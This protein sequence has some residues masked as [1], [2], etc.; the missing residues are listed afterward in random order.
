MPLTLSNVAL[1]I[2]ILL[3]LRRRFVRHLTICVFF[4]FA[5]HRALLTH[6]IF[7]QILPYLPELYYT[8]DQCSRADA[9]EAALADFARLAI[10]CKA[11]QE[12]ALDLLWKDIDSCA[13]F[14]LVLDPSLAT[15]EVEDTFE[16]KKSVQ[17]VCSFLFE[18]GDSGLCL[19]TDLTLSDMRQFRTR[20]RAYCSDE[21]SPGVFRSSQEVGS[22]R[23][24]LAQSAISV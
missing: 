3:R 4:K 10:T 22:S 17:V 24:H 8:E 1:D 20:C 11:F 15:I 13:P 14:A 6:D 5:M 7:V 16:D 9:N 23:I 2:Y 12:P 21:Q 18:T 19:M